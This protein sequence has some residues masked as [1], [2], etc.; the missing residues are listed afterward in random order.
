MKLQQHKNKPCTPTIALLSN[1]QVRD[2]G[3]I[4]TGWVTFMQALIDICKKVSKASR[5]SQISSSSAVS[6]VSG[7]V[8]GVA[9]K[10]KPFDAMN[11]VVANLLLSLTR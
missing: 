6:A 3:V 4:I 7:T 8:G 9:A 11:T 2:G 10:E 5:T 1:S